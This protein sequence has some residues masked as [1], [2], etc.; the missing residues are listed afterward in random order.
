LRCPSR[1]S[2]T[3]RRRKLD[4][5]AV[6]LPAPRAAILAVK[7][8]RERGDRGG[9]SDYE[10]DDGPRTDPIE[11]RDQPRD[12]GDRRVNQRQGFINGTRQTHGCNP[13]A[14]GKTAPHEFRRDL[15]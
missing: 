10:R 9:D 1:R 8:D 14:H 11:V 6:V 13:C 5:V 15:T 2:S 7:E 4:V 3:Q 12:Y